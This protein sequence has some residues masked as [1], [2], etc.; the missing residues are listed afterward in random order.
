MSYIADHFKINF[1]P[2]AD[3]RAVV[4][5][6]FVRFS[7]LTSR[8]IRMEYSI[9]NKF[10]DRATLAFWYRKQPVPKFEV[11]KTDTSLEIITECLH[12]KYKFNKKGFSND[13][14]SIELLNQNKTW[15]YLDRPHG[16]LKGTARTLDSVDGET[17]LQDGLLSRDGWSLIDDSSSVVFDE[18]CWVG[19]RF[20]PTEGEQEEAYKDLYFFGYGHDYKDCIRDF[21]KLSGKTP[22]FPR[23]ALGN[24][25]S[26][27]WPYTQDEL[28]NLMEEFKTYDIPLSVCIVDMDWHI[29]KNSYTTGWTGYTWN[30]DL[31]PD[32][33]G[34]ISWLHENGLRT[35]LNLHPADGVYP[36]EDQ[37]EA[38][39]SAMGKDPA[40]KDPVEFNISNP[41]FVQNYFELLHHPREEEGVDFWWMD[42]QQGTKTELKGLDP[43]PW[44]NHL[45]YYDLAR[46]GKK[47]GFV[48]SR[49]GGP[50]S[51]RYPI[52]FSGDTFVT[53]DSLKFQ[54][55]FTSTASN[56]AY[57]WWSHDIGGHM[58][59]YEDPE[60]YTRWVQYGVFSPIFRLHSTNVYYIDRHPWTKGKDVLEST[61]AA[62]KL[63]HALIPYIYS[64]MWRN[65]TEDLS[66]IV[67]MYHEHPEVEEAY[68]CPD[69]Y[70]FG[71]ELIAAPFV[72][73]MDRDLNLSR[74]KLWLPE[75]HWFNLF[76]GEHYD[77]G[78]IHAL[79][80]EL[81][82]IPVVA[83]AGAIVPMAAEKSL[84]RTENPSDFHIYIFPGGSGSFKLYED[85]GV[86]TDYTKGLYAITPLSTAWQDNKMIFTIGSA[87]GS[88]EILPESRTYNLHFRG[89]KENIS[90]KALIDGK[91]IEISKFYDASKETL[92]LND[93]ELDVK[94]T[95]QVSIITEDATL[96]SQQDR[97]DDHLR[98]LIWH[99]KY[100]GFSKQWLDEVLIKEKQP[101]SV[102]Y[103]ARHPLS[104]SQIRAIAEILKGEE[105]SNLL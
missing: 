3:E 47:R 63:R 36:H 20:S 84:E 31:F 74:Q 33:K 10:E 7:I 9:E 103:K 60:L 42:W 24:W 34:F 64:M 95:L 89:I 54:P 85:D 16:N 39:A 88:R 51:H 61:R 87:E 25:W 27:Y 4:T 50:G 8:I 80:G 72:E 82:D 102:L 23:W 15:H 13:S 53:W 2:K 79:Y 6:P 94:S 26:R 37:Y 65:H 100:E 75:G 14:L 104:A 40:A 19:R 41:K 99:M 86:S 55:Y 90:I 91:E 38:M 11:I 43:L 58:G 57:G 62:M 1:Q 45:H 93:I 35:A 28:K 92:V 98:K 18:N 29:V 73:P 21:V 96:L 78:K 76:T 17:H 105:L 59:G 66:P 44:L 49:Y 97:R 32:P 48:F 81:I 69:Q 71:T 46:D 52:G 77:G 101:I 12:L 30:K 56:I 22:M 68:H 5:A 70:Y 67:P 83:K